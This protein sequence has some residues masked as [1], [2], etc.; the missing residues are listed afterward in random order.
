LTLAHKSGRAT[1]AA[2]E[3]LERRRAGRH[4]GLG[5]EIAAHIEPWIVPSR[6][7]DADVGPAS[8]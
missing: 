8:P 7:P 6:I 5:V 1:A 2:D 3:R 4:C